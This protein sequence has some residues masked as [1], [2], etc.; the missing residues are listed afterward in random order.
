MAP[1]VRCA[2]IG[3][4]TNAEY[5][6]HARTGGDDPSKRETSNR[7]CFIVGLA[8]QASIEA[9]LGQCLVSILGNIP[10]SSESYDIKDS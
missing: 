6:A 2:I 5:V 9:G 7:F 3:E 4:N 10:P 1:C 8:S